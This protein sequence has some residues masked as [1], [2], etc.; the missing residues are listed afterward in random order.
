MMN[1]TAAVLSLF[2]KVDAEATKEDDKDLKALKVH[3]AGSQKIE[4][5]DLGAFIGKFNVSAY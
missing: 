5:F 1:K 4:S 2:Y 3:E